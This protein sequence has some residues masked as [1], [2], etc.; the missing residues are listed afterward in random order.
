M[1]KYIRYRTTRTKPDGTKYTIDHE[2]IRDAGQQIYDWLTING[3]MRRPEAR[4]T[5]A[6][7]EKTGR[8]EYIENTWTIE[9]IDLRKESDQLRMF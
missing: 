9:R 8:L 1:A 3:Y 2:K 6:N 7:A 5:A 4:T